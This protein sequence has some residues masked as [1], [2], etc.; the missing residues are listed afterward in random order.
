LTDEP[1][2]FIVLPSNIAGGG[3][4]H[5]RAQV[6][7]RVVITLGAMALVCPRPARAQAPRDG[8]WC[9]RTADG[10]RVS[11]RV[12]ASGTQVTQGTVWVLGQYFGQPAETAVGFD[13]SILASGFEYDYRFPGYCQLFR[14]VSGAFDSDHSA[15][16]TAWWAQSGGVACAVGGGSEGW[17][18]AWVSPLAVAGSADVTADLKAPAASAAA[19]AAV[20][21]PFALRNNGPDPIACLELVLGATAGGTPATVRAIPDGGLPYRNHGLWAGSLAAGATLNGVVRVKTEVDATGE[22]E[23]TAGGTPFE[24]GDP[25]PSNNEA[26][27]RM[28]LFSDADLAVALEGPTYFTAGAFLSYRID[29]NQKGPSLARNTRVDVVPSPPL[30]LKGVYSGW[31]SETPCASPC[32]LG[33]VKP[34]DG[35]LRFDFEAPAGS[36]PP[37]AFTLRATARSDTADSVPANSDAMLT[38]TLLPE[39]PASSFHTLPP[40]RLLDT[41]ETSPSF[42]SL[43]SAIDVDV[44][45]PSCGVPASAVAVSLNVS[46]VLPRGEGF[47]TVFP[48]GFPVPGTSSLNFTNGQTRANNVI[49]RV[50]PTHRITL[51]VDAPSPPCVHALV[52]VNGYFE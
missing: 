46:A 4:L 1:P 31:F 6:L 29:F 18:A 38:T 33:E 40:C 30:V 27:A 2:H 28:S 20:D 35:R 12:E 43:C 21:L 39:A 14:H 19:G 26:I 10:G 34:G 24:V 50:P 11:F 45:E 49:V 44:T 9:G 5:S 36:V 15:F 23:V 22:L 51:R 13:A 3:V 37:Q 47:L 52:D 7:F 42:P 41:R 8:L 48:A 17:S 32:L 25:N 16:G